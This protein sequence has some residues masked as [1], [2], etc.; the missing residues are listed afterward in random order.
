LFSTD[1]EGFVCHLN[2]RDRWAVEMQRRRDTRPRGTP[3]WM[4]DLGD[5]EYAAEM[6]RRSDGG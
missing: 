4:L 5:D 3:R 2:E 6:R 1:G